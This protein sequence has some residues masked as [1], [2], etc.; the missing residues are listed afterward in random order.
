MGLMLRHLLDTDAAITLLRR[1]PD[2]DLS[3][4][5]EYEGKLAISTVSILELEYGSARSAAPEK[6][7][8]AVENLL[9]TLKVLD[10]DAVAARHAGQIRAVLA[11]AGTQIGKYDLQI[12]G[13]ARSLGLTV[14][15]GNVSEFERVPGLL[16]ENWIRSA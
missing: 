3:R 2:V 8:K 10:F 1:R 6:S 7:R 11:A 9:G 5:A 14:V 12:A 4:F 13:H 15:T 16:V